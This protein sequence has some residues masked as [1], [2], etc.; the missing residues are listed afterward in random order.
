MNTNTKAVVRIFLFLLFG[1]LYASGLMLYSHSRESHNDA[2]N[3]E[4]Y[5][6]AGSS[7]D[8]N[9]RHYEKSFSVKE[10][11]ELNLIADAGDIKINSWEKNE[12]QVLV[13]LR[14][15]DSRVEKYTVEFNQEGDKVSILGRTKDR[16]FFQWNFGSLE[17]KYTIMLPKNFNTDLKSSGG[18]ISVQNVNGTL[19]GKTSGGNITLESLNGNV[20]IKTSGGEVEISTVTGNIDA[21]TSGGNVRI[22][23]VIGDISAG[24][25]GGNIEV[26]DASG[27][28]KTK[29]S[30]GDIKL[31]LSGD[32]K[33]IDAKTSGGDITLYINENI[34]ATVDAET[35]GGSVNCE[36]PVTVKG[37]VERSEL[38]GK[39]NGGGNPIRLET[40]GG[41]IRISALKK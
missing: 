29:T 22:E 5:E 33:G 19:K 35:S 28:I 39:I 36:L 17:V 1:V 15:S 14:G 20:E 32:N 3:K 9:N 6:S 24:S 30:G 18:D 11:G 4:K 23:K 37:K 34:S 26:Y 25:S 27:N 13:D 41:D 31:K 8:R 12:V 10:G 7:E 16:S 38:H 2:W 40:S 21:H